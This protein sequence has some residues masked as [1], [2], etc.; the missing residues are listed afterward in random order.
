MKPT[1]L[2]PAVKYFG[3]KSGFM[4]KIY[5]HFPLDNSYKIFVDAFGGSGSVL[6]S[7]PLGHVEIYN[8]LWE[9]VYSLYK[10]ISEPE[11][12]KQFKQKCDL[13][14][15]HEKISGEYKDL[16]KQ[17]NLSILERAFYYWYV[18]R[19]RHN[20]MGGFSTNCCIRR[21]MSKST[22][23]FLSC[24]DRLQEIHDRLSA[25][26]ILNKDA[27][28]VI[29]KYD[30][31]NVFIYCDSPYHWSTRTSSRYPVDMND[32]QHQEYINL[33]LDCKAK[34]LL[35]GYACDAYKKLETKFKRIDFIVKT[36]TGDFEKKIK[37]E[38]LWKN[39]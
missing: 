1:L 16:L 15:Y 37:T 11:L 21:N 34:I 3:G 17:T 9:N 25:V 6:L 28:E 18:N 32:E 10:V 31:D 12:F 24:I 2:R 19:T 7:R 36:I 8:D 39:Y 35:S 4:N 26:V 13:A 23:D 38:S 14:L 27:L 29:K 33:L 5:E 20:G 22:S 30:S